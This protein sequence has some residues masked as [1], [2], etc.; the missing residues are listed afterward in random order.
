M[1]PLRVKSA[2]SVGVAAMLQR[3]AMA[4]S[5]ALLDDVDDNVAVGRESSSVMHRVV[6][7]SVVG[8]GTILSIVR[9]SFSR[10]VSHR[11]DGW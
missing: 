11:T 7:L 3:G 10:L 5:G 6:L 4:S 1:V 8:G 9:T 2:S